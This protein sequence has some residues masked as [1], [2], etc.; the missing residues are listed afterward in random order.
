MNKF[1]FADCVVS[2]VNRDKSTLKFTVDALIVKANNSQNSNYTESYADTAVIT[3]KNIEII[4][5]LKEGYN[6]YDADDNLIEE[7]PDEPIA[8]SDY[9]EVFKSWAGAYLDRFDIEDGEY[10]IE[11]EMTDEVGAIAD[12]YELHVTSDN[13]TVTWDRYLNRVM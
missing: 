4:A 6:H 10:V 12:S 8:P 1:S 13:A 9:P 7:V 3:L 2:E 5:L 11:I